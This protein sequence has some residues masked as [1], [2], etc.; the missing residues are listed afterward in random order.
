MNA[1][2]PKLSTRHVT[3]RENHDAQGRDVLQSSFT[4]ESCR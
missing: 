3:I 1:V 2:T 4:V